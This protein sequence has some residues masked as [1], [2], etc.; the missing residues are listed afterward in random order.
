M[1]RLRPP[2][3]LLLSQEGLELRPARVYFIN[4]DAVNLVG[5]RNILTSGGVLIDHTPPEPT[6]YAKQRPK[7]EAIKVLAIF[8]VWFV[9]WD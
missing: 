8:R 5:Y 7:R 6:E 3:L 9:V 1:V 2:P 4:L